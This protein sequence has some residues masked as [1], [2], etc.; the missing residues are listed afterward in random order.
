MTTPHD[1]VL[2]KCVEE[3][4]LR[5]LAGVGEDVDV[6][7]S[8]EVPC[9]FEGNI[10]FADL[11]I[12]TENRKTLVEV[13]PILRDLGALLR[14]VKKYRSE[15]EPDR[16]V[17]AVCEDL[18]DDVKKVLEHEGVDVCVFDLPDPWEVSVYN[19]KRQLKRKKK[20]Y[21]FRTGGGMGWR[22]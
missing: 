21:E 2:L 10:G 18:D 6:S 5:K 17:L 9:F 8:V 13:K 1:D 12:K 3:E 15:L 16:V 4:N 7:W 14:Q 19:G 22:E 11:V 20:A